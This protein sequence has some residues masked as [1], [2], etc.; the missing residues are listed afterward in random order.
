[1]FLIRSH[2]KEEAKEKCNI[3]KQSKE[4]TCNGPVIPNGLKFFLFPLEVVSSN[5]VLLLVA[6]ARLRR[7]PYRR[8]NEMHIEAK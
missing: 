8:Q 1:M 2:R 6:S 3:L 7:Y 5:F 4:I